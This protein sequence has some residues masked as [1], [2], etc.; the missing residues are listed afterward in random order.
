MPVLGQ[1]AVHVQL[2]RLA[3]RVCIRAYKKAGFELGVVGCRSCMC[4]AGRVKDDGGGECELLL[5]AHDVCN[6]SYMRDMGFA[7]LRL[8]M[9]MLCVPRPKRIR[10]CQLHQ[11]VRHPVH[12]RYP[13][14]WRCLPCCR[15]WLSGWASPLGWK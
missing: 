10:L 14:G 6:A 3:G 8:R 13:R 4:E 12:Q 1:R 2:G 7:W 11:C 9:R 15:G 5:C